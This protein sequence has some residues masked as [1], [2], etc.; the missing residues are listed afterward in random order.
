MFTFFDRCVVG[1][2]SKKFQ[3]QTDQTMKEVM[4][5]FRKDY[6]DV[7]FSE[8]VELCKRMIREKSRVHYIARESI[9]EA[10]VARAKY[11]FMGVSLVGVSL[12][13]CKEY[14]PTYFSLPLIMAFTAMLITILTIEITYRMREKAAFD[15]TVSGFKI[16]YDLDPAY[17]AALQ[18]LI[19]IYHEEERLDL[20]LEAGS[21]AHAGGNN[22]VYA[23]N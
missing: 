5:N 9:L 7:P 11:L 18:G 13:I 17:Q 2:L 16:D 6:H 12:S 10:G 4:R 20:D 15:S 23:F 14:E 19:I 21:L 8:Y 22:K 3:H 1:A